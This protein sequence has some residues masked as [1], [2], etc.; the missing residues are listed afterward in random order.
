MIDTWIVIRVIE[1]IDI[2]MDEERGELSE[3]AFVHENIH[4][5]LDYWSWI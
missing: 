4:G 5:N 2:H 1:V 3:K